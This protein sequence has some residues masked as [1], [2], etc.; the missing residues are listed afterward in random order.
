MGK[1]DFIIQSGLDSTGEP[2]RGLLN[3]SI[4]IGTKYAA[5]NIEVP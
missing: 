3:A 4:T 5:N 1:Q 2:V